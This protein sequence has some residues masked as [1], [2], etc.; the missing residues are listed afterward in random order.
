MPCQRV[1]DL[2]LRVW[3]HFLQKF[4]I[5]RYSKYN[6]GDYNGA[7][8]ICSGQFVRM[9]HRETEAFLRYGDVV[10]GASDTKGANVHFRAGHKLH[11][12][13]MVRDESA[14]GVT[15]TSSNGV[16]EVK[17]TD[18]EE[19]EKLNEKMRRASK[20]NPDVARVFPKE[21]GGN[22]TWEKLFRFKH[23]GTEKYLAA[24]FSGGSEY[25]GI[26]FYLC[27]LTR[28]KEDGTLEQLPG[29]HLESLWRVSPVNPLQKSEQKREIQFEEVFHL[30][31]AVSG[32]WAK[33][34]SSPEGKEQYYDDAHSEQRSVC[35]MIKL[36]PDAPYEDAFGFVKVRDDPEP[37]C[38]VRDISK[39][40]AVIPE[41]DRY[42]E[43]MKSGKGGPDS[44]LTK[45]IEDLLSDL[46]VNWITKDS[47]DTN[48]KTR[49]AAVHQGR[50]QQLLR[51]QGVLDQL[52]QITEAKPYTK[53]AG[54]S[55]QMMTNDVEELGPDHPFYLTVG[56]IMKLCWI[57]NCLMKYAV[58]KNN[59]NSLYMIPHIEKYREQIGAGEIG[60]SAMNI[61]TVLHRNNRPL[62]EALEATLFEGWVS[63]VTKNLAAGTVVG[64]LHVPIRFLTDTCICDGQPVRANQD[65]IRK[66][67]FA[68]QEPLVY[69]DGQ[70]KPEKEQRKIED[71]GWVYSDA[72]LKF[73]AD[74]E[75]VQVLDICG[76]VPTW[77]FIADMF[78]DPDPAGIEMQEYIVASIRLYANM[79]AANKDCQDHVIKLMPKEMVETIIMKD[80]KGCEDIRAACCDLLFRLYIDANQA[81][82]FEAI[83]LTRKFEEVIP[84]N[85]HK[86]VLRD[87][88]PFPK[89]KEWIVTFLS[90][91]TKM[92]A[93]KEC[94]RD[95]LFVVEVCKL[96][97]NLLRFGV[98]TD[99]AELEA[100]LRPLLAILD[101]QTDDRDTGGGA[102]SKAEKP[103]FD[104]A[105]AQWRTKVVGSNLA[106]IQAKTEICKI[107][108]RVQEMALSLR[109]TQTLL[110]FR[111]HLDKY[112]QHDQD[113]DVFSSEQLQA[114]IHAGSKL[115]NCPKQWTA[116]SKRMPEMK[117]MFDLLDAGHNSLRTMIVPGDP[118]RGGG[119]SSS[120]INDLFELSL[121]PDAA[122]QAAA[123]KVMS[124]Q[125][126]QRADLA[127]NL[128]QV[129]LL[130][131]KDDVEFFQLAK[132]MLSSIKGFLN[133]PRKDVD[134]TKC[135]ENVQKAWS[136]LE[137]AKTVELRQSYQRLFKN[138]QF[139]QAVIEV[140]EVSELEDQHRSETGMQTPRFKLLTKCYMFLL[141][142]CKGNTEIKN[143][144][145]FAD[146]MGMFVD[147]LDVKPF[148]EGATHTVDVMASDLVLELY[149]DNKPLVASVNSQLIS[150]FVSLI[151]NNGRLPTWLQF[152]NKI[153]VVG[154]GDDCEPI[155]K[156]Q[157]QVIKG[158]IQNKVKTLTGLLPCEALDGRKSPALY[159]SEEEWKIC[160][161]LMESQDD[162]SVPPT[163]GGLSYHIE[164]IDLMYRCARGKNKAAEQLCQN[165]LPLEAI[166]R[167]LIDAKTI[168]VVKKAYLNF[169]WE[170][171]V[172]LERPKRA[173]PYKDEIWDVLDK[174][175]DDL[176]KSQVTMISVGL[177]DNFRFSEEY[178]M[179]EIQYLYRD[180]MKFL[181]NW[182]QGDWYTEQKPPPNCS[183]K[184]WF[185][186][187]PELEPWSLVETPDQI[188]K[189]RTTAKKLFDGV[190]VLLERPADPCCQ[191]GI[192]DTEAGY[193]CAKTMLDAGIKPSEKYEAVAK[194]FAEKGRKAEDADDQF[195]KDS[196]VPPNSKLI[197]LSFDL[198]ATDVEAAVDP[199]EEV[200]GLAK[201]MRNLIDP[202]PVGQIDHNRGFPKT[203]DTSGK[204]RGDQ[205][206]IF[207]EKQSRYVSAVVH[208]ITKAG[209]EGSHA[210]MPWESAEEVRRQLLVALRLMMDPAMDGKG[211]YHELI[212]TPQTNKTVN[213]YFRWYEKEVVQLQK[214]ACGEI[215]MPNMICHMLAK[216]EQN[217]RPL[218]EATLDLFQQLVF[219][220]NKLVQES[221]RQAFISDKKR[222]QDVFAQLQSRLVQGQNEAKTGGAKV[223]PPVAKLPL[224]IAAAQD[225]TRK[226]DVI[227]EFG[228]VIQIFQI[229]KDLCEDNNQVMKNFMK[230]QPTDASSDL[231]KEVVDFV[232]A[233]QRNLTVTNVE[234]GKF[235]FKALTELV[236]GPCPEN[237]NSLITDLKMDT[238]N[239][240]FQMMTDEDWPA[241]VKYGQGEFARA[242]EEAKREPCH[243]TFHGFDEDPD[244]HAAH[245]SEVALCEVMCSCVKMLQ[246]MLEGANED[247]KDRLLKLLGELS[248]EQMERAITLIYLEHQES[249]SS[250]LT[251]W[252]PGSR[253]E[254]R[255]WVLSKPPFDQNKLKLAFLM[256]T[257]HRQIH[258][259][260]EDRK[261]PLD[262]KA[263]YMDQDHYTVN[264]NQAQYLVRVDKQIRNVAQSAV[265]FFYDKMARIEILR[266]VPGAK[267]RCE[268]VYFQVP[269]LCFLLPQGTKD[270]LKA[271]VNR[272]SEE[273][274]LSDFIQRADEYQ[275]E[276]MTQERLQ[277]WYLYRSLVLEYQIGVWFANTVYWLGFVVNFV[278]IVFLEH[279]DKFDADPQANFDP[280]PDEGELGTMFNVLDLT[281][282][283]VTLWTS[284]NVDHAGGYDKKAFLPIFAWYVIRYLGIIL[285]FLA[286][287]NFF[288]YIFG[289]AELIAYK[290]FKKAHNDQQERLK[291]E[292][293]KRSE[294]PEPAIPWR[295]SLYDEP[296][297]ILA[298]SIPT[299]F[300]RVRPF[301]Y[302]RAILYVVQDGGFIYQSVIMTIIILGYTWTPFVY[303]L[304]FFIIL[305][306]DA[307]L[308]GA[309]DAV[310]KPIGDILKVLMLTIIF[311]Y[312][313]TVIGFVFFHDQFN[314]G[315]KKEDN[316]CNSLLQC[317]IFTIYHGII[318]NEIWFDAAPGELWPTKRYDVQHN[319][320]NQNAWVFFIR[321][322]LDI[323]F[324]L[325]VGVTLI[326]GVLF[327]IILDK[328]AELRENRMAVD[329]SHQ[330]TCFICQNSR[331]E[332]DKEGA[333]GGF[334]MHV[335]DDHHLWHYINFYIYLD[336]IDP[337]ELN[338]PESYVWGL[339]HEDPFNLD[340][341]PRGEALVLVKEEPEDKVQEAV[342][343]VTRME[344]EMV[345]MRRE[346]TDLKAQVFEL[347]TTAKILEMNAP[348]G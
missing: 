277:S 310:I 57:S 185:H 17:Q 34:A 36:V 81:I 82:E 66:Y 3:R 315:D 110:A 171:Y 116:I 15:K 177:P 252:K 125:Y 98:Y 203:R 18:V 129:Q 73:R 76:H 328:Y 204:H 287:V 130:C 69:D 39:I 170:S 312:V 64:I 126:S 292:A 324:F 119:T 2:T 183:D 317:L 148:P 161:E 242:P 345:E 229:M 152:L 59:N 49:D 84:A 331:E 139:P 50:R 251:P 159:K 147:H 7:V 206:L 176:L 91:R 123:F 67:L 216:L 89:L 259:C 136:E 37:N 298:W 153:A 186:Y 228:Y 127:R 71:E 118:K 13:S 237:Q 87:D 293:I 249:A 108:Q 146:N 114:Y 267:P 291:Q 16:W 120:F 150:R 346:A 282:F 75:S 96:I 92:T 236:I 86:L 14:E 162:K 341:L 265:E 258:D 198:L 122:L 143:D 332:L 175:A 232:V 289:N 220:G 173:T 137:M 325:L 168:P 184:H 330:N 305:N 35:R 23:V 334:Q 192:K 133:G 131:S 29:A 336:L 197:Q 270:R 19:I 79:C 65:A 253:E 327:G 343:T 212:L 140:V 322:L 8:A 117:T 107:L 4:E 234:Q 138:V 43:W 167:G 77:R 141:A 94:E 80:D 68:D 255:K 190:C 340:W 339:L 51:E 25:G 222:C 297:G 5:R 208:H 165:E 60:K 296:K 61:L 47:T 299:G 1:R 257:L 263:E 256:L 295:L 225:L 62:L 226:Q 157:Q 319:E 28:E 124:Q 46:I 279:E 181:T 211:S 95:N 97:L 31:H 284:Y 132:S 205:T 316:M 201:T 188:D 145:V 262:F 121:C 214:V 283:P 303:G 243:Q 100:V 202:E 194:S 273:E 63:M 240:L 182:F 111:S 56:N 308:M 318:S 151:V 6:V 313:F 248:T 44:K 90:E 304:L 9:L 26:R 155:K 250:L 164:L 306:K 302:L 239:D 83:D 274:K 128:R 134:E 178:V 311:M 344:T 74:G 104:P 154:D 33:S 21:S 27:D 231:F 115:L 54:L 238:I 187:D 210:A 200:R 189:M 286:G 268:R 227:V 290:R 179:A 106:L 10:T 309:M 58:T 272:S 166:H 40:K 218:T 53:E 300:M 38:E 158:L 85:A 11:L 278:M 241:I 348:A 314:D 219:R 149:Q 24:S 78:Q 12:H 101:S 285:I 280:D 142:C 247:T 347:L 245:K 207:K 281:Q 156:N 20:N 180:A 70:V 230:T 22:I 269:N 112:V 254:L 160:V 195:G 174:L 41:L 337:T 88:I 294:V 72:V 109:I 321:S 342:D 113:P 260:K 199:E 246:A 235:A 32:H 191:I 261:R 52:V 93:A 335:D 224:S 55:Y 102:D 217:E 163:P 193:I 103:E 42:I 30:Q 135:A 323:L 221:V 307:E 264:V 213:N 105:D 326:G 320:E 196:G 333:S 276:M 215:E 338:G 144:R 99:L 169:L 301:W 209:D 223:T 275:K 45:S 271:S 266:E 233:W 48:W 288:L 172:E 244:D 329:E